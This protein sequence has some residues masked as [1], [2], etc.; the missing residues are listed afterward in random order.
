M[1]TNVTKFGIR[2]HIP[3]LDT[4][5]NKEVREFFRG[6]GFVPMEDGPEDQDNTPYYQ[7][8]D[9]ESVG[10][11]YPIMVYKKGWGL[12]HLF[13]YEKDGSTAGKEIRTLSDIM[14]CTNT[15][16]NDYGIDSDNTLVFAYTWYR[17]GDEPV[18]FK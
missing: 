13:H 7:G 8:G 12:E 6:L 15:M 9:K 16:T 14:E 17:G 5:S 3:Q 4:K 2:A 11:T 10:T 1:S 18:F